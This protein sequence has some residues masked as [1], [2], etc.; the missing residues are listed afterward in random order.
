MMRY[1]SP[2]VVLDLVK[3]S[4]KKEREVRVSN[5]NEYRHAIDYIRVNSSIDARHKIQYCALDYSHI[6]MSKHRHLDVSESLNEVTTSRRHDVG[7]KSDWIL[8][9]G[10]QM[11]NSK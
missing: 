10:T 1:G 6:S 3:Q 5:E 2:I 8:L 9:F 7:C 4:E 11:E